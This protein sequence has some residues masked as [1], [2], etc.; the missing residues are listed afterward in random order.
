[1]DNGNQLQGLLPTI[2]EA[3]NEDYDII[4]V[5]TISEENI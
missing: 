4:D 3:D 1:M 5:D 2:I